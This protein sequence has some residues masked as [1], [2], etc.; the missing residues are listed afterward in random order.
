VKAWARPR[1]SWYLY[2]FADAILIFNGV[3]YFPKWIVIES[4]AGEL[5]YNVAFAITTVLLLVTA[6]ITGHL[7]DVKYGRLFCLRVIRYAVGG[8][9]L[10]IYVSGIVFPPGTARTLVALV[11]F[12]VLM[13]GHQASSAF[14]TALLPRVVGPDGSYLDVAGNGYAFRR[15][16]AVIGILALLPFGRGKIRLIEHGPPEPFL[17]AALVYIVLTAVAL[18]F[19]PDDP[20]QSNA[21]T[22]SLGTIMRALWR[23]VLQI[24]HDRRL[25]LF[26][27]AYATFMDAILTVEGNVTLYMERI[28]RLGESPQ[29]YLLLLLLVMSALGARL[30][31]PFAAQYGLKRAF[32]VILVAW[33]AILG[34]ISAARGV[35]FFSVM[36][37]LA[38]VAYGAVSNCARVTYLLLIPSD[39][40]A[41]YLGLYASF[42]RCASVTGPLAWGATVSLLGV[43]AGYRAAVLVMAALIA[44][45]LP[46]IRRIDLDP[47][48]RVASASLA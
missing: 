14:Y 10:V 35:A 8:A 46:L 2:D 42:E 37:A 32:T 6:P 41:E 48:E 9:A 47:A 5:A 36:F 44:V 39:R 16:G 19:M 33:I 43:G 27:I 25:L 17:L 21:E 28:M 4:G 11:A 22:M 13:Y 38:G 12:G 30:S 15:V 29:A 3:L 26:L 23:D 31:A 20:P 1:W 34:G 24:R 40:R 18:R 45:S 7:S